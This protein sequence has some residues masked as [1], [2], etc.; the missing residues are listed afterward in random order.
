MKTAT[1][2]LVAVVLAGMLA[3]SGGAPS[4]TT[5][6]DIEA[7]VDAAVAGAWPTATLTPRPDINA[8]IFAGMEATRVAEPTRTPTPP[9]KP[10]LDATVEA[11]LAATLAAIPTPTPPPTNTPHPTSTTTLAPEPTL[12]PTP[13]FVPT[14]T[15]RPTATRRP[16]PTPTPAPAVV[17]LSEMVRQARPAVVRIETRT[18][19]GSGVIFE[20]QGQ[21]GY[22]LTN[23]HVVEGYRQVDVVVDDSRAYRG[24]VRGTDRVRDLAVVS[25]C[26][27]RFQ[28]LAFGDSSSLEPGDEV[29]AI[30]Y[31]LGLSGGATITSGIV[32]ATRF[33]AAHQSEVIQTDAAINPGN[34]GGPLLSPVGEILGINTFRYVESDSGRPTEGLGFA[35]SEETVRARIPALKAGYASPNPTPTRR[36]RSTSS[37][38]GVGFGPISG[39]LRHDPSDGFIK[40]EY[41]DVFLADFIVSATFVNPYS[42]LLNSWDYGFIFREGFSGPSQQ[43]LVN[44]LGRWG[45]WA[46]DEPPRKRVAW[47]TLRSF[48]TSAGGR[49]TLFV[50]VFGDRGLLFVNREFISF[51]DLTGDAGMGDIAVITGAFTGDEVAGAVTRF[52]DFQIFPLRKGYGPASGQL[53]REP[54][55]VAEHSSGVWTRDLVAEATFSSPP[56]RNWDYGFILRN[57]ESGRLDV[58]GVTGSADWFHKA[59]D[60]GDTDYR[61]VAGATLRE[62][63]ATIA[64]RNH[65]VL[66]ALDDV[67]LF[68]VNDRFVARLDLSHNLEYGGFSVMSD[69][70]REHENSTRFSSF[71]VWTP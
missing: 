53:Q 1:V 13:T 50:A 32:S 29:V 9:P 46:G 3:C 24:T 38:A 64:S 21:T 23:Y 31:A 41:A 10:D 49:N 59:R 34:S 67:G 54:G 44:S 36:P 40:A 26:C 51:L 58:V 65:L 17:S 43:I 63:G 61:T 70:F 33:D 4:T 42:S 48:D 28:P 25:I 8:T 19:N 66:F 20:S 52:E 6:P 2:L 16:L 30:G 18:G 35:I 37:P 57:P 15:P 56:G 14:P 22:L 5:L 47:G 11:R 71:N 27:G 12:T 68:F 39:E 45:L 62:S 55:F 60:L 69:F 7:T